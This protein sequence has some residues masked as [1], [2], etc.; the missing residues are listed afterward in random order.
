MPARDLQ[1]MTWP[2]IR[3]WYR[4]YERQVAEEEVKG[5]LSQSDKN[6]K[7]KPM[8]SPKRIRELT[9]KKLAEWRAERGR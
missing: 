8:P 9:D 7:T 3:R 6:G 1:A 2:K 5:E 4:I